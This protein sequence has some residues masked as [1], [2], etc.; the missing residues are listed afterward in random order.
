[1]YQVCLA[2]WLATVTISTTYDNNCNNNPLRVNPIS[3]NG[4][5]LTPDGESEVRGWAA[6]PGQARPLL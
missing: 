4:A 5:E 2:V 1:M 6:R 3:L